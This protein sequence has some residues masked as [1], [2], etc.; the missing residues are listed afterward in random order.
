MIEVRCVAYDVMGREV[1]FAMGFAT[2]TAH[3]KWAALQGL[4]ARL[5][6]SPALA[7]K[8]RRKSFEVL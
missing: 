1:A 6:A 8:V 7:G 4:Q 2:R 3:A 5:S